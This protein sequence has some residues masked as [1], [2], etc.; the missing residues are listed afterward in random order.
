V[1]KSDN[2]QLSLY[3]TKALLHSE[4]CK[5]IYDYEVQKKLHS[6]VC[7]RLGGLHTFFTVYLF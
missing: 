6:R 3:L 4:F 1:Y 7:S 5:D 2:G